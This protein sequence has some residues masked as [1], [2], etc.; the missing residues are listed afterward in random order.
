MMRVVDP[1]VLRHPYSVANAVV[2]GVLMLFLQTSSAGEQKVVLKDDLYLGA[3]KTIE[4]LTVWPVFTDRS[5]VKITGDFITLAA[6]QRQQTGFVREVGKPGH[7][8]QT[9][10]N[11]RHRQRRGNRVEGVVGEL[12]VENKGDKPILIL[13]GTLLK[14]GKQDRQVGQDFIV[15]PRKTVPVSAFCVE[16]GRWSA[17]REG[18]STNGQFKAQATLATRNVRKSGQYE[19]DQGKVWQN[20]ARENKK[21]GK[22]PSSG[23]LMAAIDQA[24]KR[25]KSRRKRVEKEL[26]A[27]FDKLARQPPSPLGLAY[28]VDGRVREVRYFTHP[29]IFERFRTTLIRTM[30]IETDLAQRQAKADKRPIASGPADATQVI[31][32]VKG[33]TQIK[34]QKTKTKAG[35][36]NQ[37]RRGKK[38]YNSD[39]YAD[40]SAKQPVT[41][42]FM[43]AE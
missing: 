1:F 30:A 15:P 33:A 11:R 29:R 9:R 19:N 24:D 22:N 5:L 10:T 38:I 8:A 13:A 16:Q 14:G 36:I 39:C 28:A 25:S 35:N 37:L 27:T 7:D 4:N 20:V 41:S 32:L 31:M 43:S 42:S 21:A 17:V 23:T 34:A 6:A 2:A 40:E 12:V 18:K 26:T 3:G